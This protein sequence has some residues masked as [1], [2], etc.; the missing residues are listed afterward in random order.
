MTC[1]KGENA[2]GIVGNLLMYSSI[3]FTRW[4]PFSAHYTLTFPGGL[5]VTLS[6]LPLNTNSSGGGLSSFDGNAMV[7]TVHCSLERW[8]FSFT[9]QD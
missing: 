2:T 1:F 9:K 8:W 6:P 7:I 4:E 3:C 5:A